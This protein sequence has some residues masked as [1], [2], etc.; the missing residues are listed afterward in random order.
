[1]TGSGRS[2]CRTA[3]R[4]RK[5]R[6]M[7]PYRREKIASRVQQIV[8]EAIAFDL[9]DP[10]IEPMTSVTR[11][12]LTGDLLI[13]R[14]YLSVMGG[15]SAE[16]RTLNAVQHAGGFLQRRVAQ[17]LNIR[18]APEVRFQIDDRVKKV[19]VTLAL[20]AQNRLENPSLATDESS[21]AAEATDGNEE[22]AQNGD[23]IGDEDSGSTEA[24]DDP[25]DEGTRA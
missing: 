22:E 10:R 7:K 13:A 24:S 5:R 6:S 14:V 19:K 8:S 3:P 11:V 23:A 2:S 21:P 17:E 4:K 18:Q 16:R 15:D 1:M 12:E 25:G 20:L 9:Q